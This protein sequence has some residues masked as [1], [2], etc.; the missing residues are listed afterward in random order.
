MPLAALTHTV[1]DRGLSRVP[2]L[3]QNSGNPERE[4]GAV[5]LPL[6]Q[7]EVEAG[8]NVQSSQQHA[9]LAEPPMLLSGPG[10]PE[11]A[12]AAG[13]KV[14]GRDMLRVGHIC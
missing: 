7:L 4:R 2:L 3:L 1:L 10:V 12:A 8:A 11:G 14:V 13:S 5:Q 6:Q 9:P